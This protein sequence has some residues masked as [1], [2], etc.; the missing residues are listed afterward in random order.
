MKVKPLTKEV[1]LTKSEY[2]DLALT[3]DDVTEREIKRAENIK[4]PKRLTSNS[5][6]CVVFRCKDDIELHNLIN[7]VISPINFE[8]EILKLYEMR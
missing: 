1:T 8:H 2:R 5:K 7:G 6:Y 3:A 4:I